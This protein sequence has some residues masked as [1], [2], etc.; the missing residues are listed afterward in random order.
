MAGFALVA[1]FTPSGRVSSVRELADAQIAGG[2]EALAISEPHVVLR[3]R[4]ARALHTV[5]ELDRGRAGVV[6]PQRVDAVLRAGAVERRLLAPQQVVDAHLQRRRSAARIAGA[7]D[8][9]ER[10]LL[11]LEA[12]V[13]LAGVAAAGDLARRSRHA[14]PARRWR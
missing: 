7:G 14:L 9:G 13:R 8:V 11:E 1:L 6:L 2:A 4:Q 12:L 10:R 3:A 5:A